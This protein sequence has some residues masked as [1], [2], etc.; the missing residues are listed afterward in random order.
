MGLFRPPW[1]DTMQRLTYRS[2]L[3][4][5]SRRN[6]R[7]SHA[8]WYI[9]A[10]FSF[11]SLILLLMLEYSQVAFLSFP[12]PQSLQFALCVF[13]VLSLIGAAV[14]GVMDQGLQFEVD[15]FEKSWFDNDHHRSIEGTPSTTHPKSRF[16]SIEDC[17]HDLR[18]N[19]HDLEELI[20]ANRVSTTKVVPIDQI[21]RPDL[22]R[23][24][25]PHGHHTVRYSSEHCADRSETPASLLSTVVPHD[26]NQFVRRASSDRYFDATDYPSTFAASTYV[27]RPALSIV[28]LTIEDAEEDGSSDDLS[29]SSTPSTILVD[30][31][32]QRV[33][34]AR[35][36][37]LGQDSQ[38]HFELPYRSRS[39]PPQ[40][41]PQTPK[42]STQQRA[43]SSLPRVHRWTEDERTVLSILKRWYEQSWDECEV[44]FYEYFRAEFKRRM[45]PP[46]RAVILS[47]QWSHLKRLQTNNE[48]L[49]VIYGV[50]FDDPEGTYAAIRNQIEQI[51]AAQGIDIHP[52][53]TEN[54]ID[55]LPKSKM[56]PSPFRRR[57]G[58]HIPALL[59]SRADQ[60]ILTQPPLVKDTRGY[61]KQQVPSPPSPSQSE[62]HDGTIFETPPTRS[63]QQEAPRCQPS[64][65]VRDASG[66][67]S[68]AKCI[69]STEAPVILYRCY[70]ELSHGTNSPEL[71]RAECFKSSPNVVPVPVQDYAMFLIF[72][73]NHIW[74]HKVV[75]RF[76]IP[77][78]LMLIK[79]Y[80][81]RHS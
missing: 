63:H 59:R 79:S 35:H 77:D 31:S 58:S 36:L 19:Q 10:T 81:V 47:T 44:I 54:P 45:E 30:T 66:A 37:S 48:F 18:R 40:P 41:P 57:A 3:T 39:P 78:E 14:Y 28:D 27:H 46:T 2:S 74:H 38:H 7:C 56:T 52:A 62:D 11:T 20:E 76:S 29:V 50:T 13:F 4:A 60:E 33:P 43:Q 69:A 24:A 6:T 32:T 5:C 1:C 73:S 17:V 70:D 25:L 72:V 71:F 12:H 65:A 55:Y 26:S 16:R 42:R 15:D 64:T 49:T 21:Y 68:S 51:A 80:R 8:I 67:M 9:T 23:K 22:N 53:Q 34:G 61:L 75:R